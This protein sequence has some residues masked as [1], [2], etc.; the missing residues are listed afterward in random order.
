M[1][2]FPPASSTAA[3]SKAKLMKGMDKRY[4]GHLWM[5]TMTTN[6]SNNLSL[7]FHSLTCVGHL[8]CLNPDYEYL[9]RAYQT[10]TMNDSEFRI[11][12]VHG[13]DSMQWACIHLKHHRHPIKTGDY[14]C[15]HKKINA[16]IEEHVKRTPQAPLN[17]IVIEEIDTFLVSTF[18]EARK[19]HLKCF[20]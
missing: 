2:V 6:I 10:S 17:K 15:I 14:R 8:E 7:S 4:D 18:S 3:Q 19:I 11:F 1:F 16:F 20:L 5:K 12:Y 13:Y 9:Q